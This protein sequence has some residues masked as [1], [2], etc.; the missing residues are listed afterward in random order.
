MTNDDNND[1]F[2]WSYKLGIAG[3]KWMIKL[4]NSSSLVRVSIAI[5]RGNFSTKE[6]MS[7]D[8]VQEGEWEWK[9]HKV[10]FIIIIISPMRSDISTD[11]TVMIINQRREISLYVF[12]LS[13]VYPICFLFIYFIINKLVIFKT[14]NDKSLPRRQRGTYQ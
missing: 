1:D 10:G 4:V 3:D 7:S 8:Y 14:I 6:M 5:P 11:L 9:Q 13:I 12:Y 2:L